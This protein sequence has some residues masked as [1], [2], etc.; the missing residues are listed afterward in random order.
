[1]TTTFETIQ[2]HTLI[3]SSDDGWMFIT[4]TSLPSLSANTLV[5]LQK[6]FLITLNHYRVMKVYIKYREYIY[7][8]SIYSESV[9]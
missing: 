9:V 7:V 3:L 5:K 8:Q 6:L 4:C 1:M 2:E